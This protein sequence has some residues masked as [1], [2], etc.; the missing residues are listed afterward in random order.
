MSTRS[1]ASSLVTACHARTAHADAGADR[2]DALVVRQHGDL[3]ARRRVTRS[4]ALDFE[5]AL[6]DFR[7]FLART[8]SS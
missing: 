7:H 4:A 6:L 3:G 2:I 8:A 5:Q 1:P